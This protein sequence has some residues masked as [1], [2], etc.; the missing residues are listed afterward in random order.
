MNNKKRCFIVVCF[1]IDCK[2]QINTILPNARIMCGKVRHSYCYLQAK[3]RFFWFYVVKHTKGGSRLSKT[4]GCALCH[5]HTVRAAQSDKPPNSF[6]I[7]LICKYSSHLYP[8]KNTLKS[9]VVPKSYQIPS[10]F[11]PKSFYFPPFRK[12]EN[13]S[14]ERL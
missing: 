9:R 6:T 14:F 7:S 3:A 1:L 13:A 4:S 2:I 8:L 11:L 12:G 5:L 10:K